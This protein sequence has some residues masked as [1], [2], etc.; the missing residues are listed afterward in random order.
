MFWEDLLIKNRFLVKNKFEEIL[1]KPH[2]KQ[3]E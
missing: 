2:E 1:Y 3:K